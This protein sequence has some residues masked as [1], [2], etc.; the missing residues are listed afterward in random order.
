[1][2]G[3]KIGK[4]TGVKKKV[5]SKKVQMRKTLKMALLLLNLLISFFDFLL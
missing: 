2:E 1:M 5:R 3:N 4:H